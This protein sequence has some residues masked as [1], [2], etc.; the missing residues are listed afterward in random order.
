MQ[1][2]NDRRGAQSREVP[3]VANVLHRRRGGID[4]HIV[5]VALDEHVVI[6]VVHNDLGNLAERLFGAV[7]D[8]VTATLVEHVIGQRDVDNALEHPHVNLFH[9]LSAQRAREVVGQDHVQRVTLALHLHQMTDILV[10]LVDL[11]DQFRDVDVIGIGVRETLVERALQ[12]SRIPL[13]LC[14]LVFEAGHTR[15]AG[16]KLF[17]NVLI[18]GR[19]FTV[20]VLAV[21]QILLAGTTAHQ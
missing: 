14:K 16:S 10:A 3:V 20:L 17:L 18:V 19:Q 21:L 8:F 5:G 11:V 7:V 6:L 12:G 4:G 1:I 2:L 13:L 15:L 9:L